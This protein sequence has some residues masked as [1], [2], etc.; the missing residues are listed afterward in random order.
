M[1]IY[2]GRP[3]G[4]I[5]IFIVSFATF[6]FFYLLLNREKF[7]K[8][9]FKEYLLLSAI[10]GPFMILFMI[11]LFLILFFSNYFSVNINKK[12]ENNIQTALIVDKV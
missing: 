3:N 10:F 12:E 6:S 11:M 8:E 9:E 4:V 1:F 7:S 5:A 2:L